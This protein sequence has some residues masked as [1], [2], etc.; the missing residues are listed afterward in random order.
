MLVVVVLHF[1]FVLHFVLFFILLLLFFISLLLMWCCSSHCFLTSSFILSWIIARFFHPFYNFSP[2]HR[3]VIRDTFFLTFPRSSFHSFTASATVLSVHFLSTGIFYFTPIH[4]HFTC[5]YQG[6][7]SS[8]MFFLEVYRA[9][10]WS[11]KHRP[12][13]SVCLIHNNPQFSCSE[14]FV[15]KFYQTLLRIPCG[16]SLIYLLL[17]SFELFSL[18]QSHMSRLLK[19]NL[20]KAKL[21]LLLTASINIKVILK[22]QSGVI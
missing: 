4:Q 18:V 21:V 15:F 9:S 13:P 16:E 3:R 22:K 19:N 11:S 1:I 6:L 14:R 12:G 20:N 2:A 10:Y 7:P 5:I 17:T 8:R